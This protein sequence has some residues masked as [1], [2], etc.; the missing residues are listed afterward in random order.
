MRIYRLRS[1]HAPTGL[2]EKLDALDAIAVRSGAIGS[3]EEANLAHYLAKKAIRMKECI[4]RSLRFEFLLWLSGRTDIKNAMKATAPGCGGEYFLFVF[5]DAGQDA[6]C[7][8]LDARV[9]PLAL[10]R[11]GAPLA[12]ERISLS[13]VKA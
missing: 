5:S 11:E 6:L 13:R 8:M 1:E 9:L 4:A 12:L 7:R 2:F 10:P 3:L